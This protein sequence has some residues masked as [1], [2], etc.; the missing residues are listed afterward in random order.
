MAHSKI[1]IYQVLPRLYGN[2]HTARIPNGTLEQNGSGKMA[3]FTPE[4]LREIKALGATHIWYTGLIEHATKTDYSAQGIRPDTPAVV[5]GVAG[6]PYAIKDYYDIDPDLAI[7]ISK[8]R[9][10]FKQLVKRT[11]AVGLKVIIDFVPNHLA[12]EYH[13]DVPNTRAIPFGANDKTTHVFNPQNNFYYID[14]EPLYTDD[15]APDS[16]YHEQ[17]A[18]ATGNDRFDRWPSRSDWYETIKL[19]YG[20]DYQAGKQGHFEPIPDTWHKMLHILRYWAKRGVDGFRCDMAEMVPCEFWQWAIANL[21][22]EFPKIIFIAEIYTPALYRDYIYRGGFDYLYDKVGMYDTLR[23]VMCG[24]IS[25]SAITNAWQSVDDISTHMLHFLENHD[26]QRIASVFFAG[27]ALAGRA[28]LVVSACLTPS[29]FMLYA[30]QEWGEA[31]MDEEGFSGRDG[32]TTIFDYWTI[33]TL[34]RARYATDKLTY[35]EKHLQQYYAQVLQLCNIETALREGKTFD[36]MY[37][38][39]MPNAGFDPHSH[40]VFIRATDSEGIFIAANFAKISS[41]AHVTIPAHAFEY[42]GI[43]E[44]HYEAIDLLT[45]KVQKLIL[46]T[47]TPAK[48]EIPAQSAVMLKFVFS[49]KQHNETQ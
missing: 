39:H 45:A 8:R 14:Q 36:L 1:I 7:N 29:P 34:Y 10:E 12:R 37:A 17:P 4:V 28:A 2:K 38:N 13:S 24:Y 32:R 18:K 9:D 30:G 31:G 48:I 15:F 47:H 11:H 21:K 49:P 46:N 23:G 41:N 26:E 25:A 42:L 35:D 40:Y 6:S 16:N 3:D 20:V 27:T 44:G 43:P 33:D 5:K 19:N 22:A